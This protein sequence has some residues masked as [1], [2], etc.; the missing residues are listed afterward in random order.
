MREGYQML[1]RLSERE[2]LPTCTMLSVLDA[3]A[4]LLDAC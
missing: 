1:K 3:P 2:D 4:E